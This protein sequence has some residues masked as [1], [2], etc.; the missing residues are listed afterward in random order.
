MRACGDVRMP[1]SGWNDQ[2]V[3]LK[4]AAFFSTAPVES[5][6]TRNAGI[7]CLAFVSS[8]ASLSRHASYDRWRL[9]CCAQVGTQCFVSGFSY[10]L[11]LCVICHNAVQ[12]H[13]RFEYQ[14]M[15]S[16]IDLQCVTLKKK[17]KIY[18]MYF[19]S[20]NE[21]LTLTTVSED[22]PESYTKFLVGHDPQQ[23]EHH[24]PRFDGETAHCFRLEPIS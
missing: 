1:S 9:L 15:L 24:S 13:Q 12:H 20:A 4:L 22:V 18:Y 16:I 19:E 10:S 11:T 14:N 6:G 23:C 21:T 3:D 8:S 2:K 7:W 17:G 5:V